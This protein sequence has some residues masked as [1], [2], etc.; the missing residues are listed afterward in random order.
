MKKKLGLFFL[1]S[2]SI[3]AR[4][5]TLES[6]IQLGMDNNKEIMIS[7]KEVQKTKLNVNV[8]FKEAL[9]S[10]VYTGSYNKSEYDRNVILSKKPTDR[11]EATTR[12]SKSSYAQSIS[13]N[14]PLFTGGV[15]TSGIKYAKASESI[16]E[17]NYLGKQRDVRLEII[18]MY[19][20][21]VATNKNLEAL[22]SSEKE[23]KA[24]YERQ[25]R[26]LDLELITKSDLL[27]TEY[28]LLDVQS[29]IIATSNLFKIQMENLKVKL[30][31]PITE[32]L[33]IREFT[34]PDNLVKNINFDI[35]KK[36]ALEESI[37]AKISNYTLDLAN[38]SKGI[39]RAEFMP[40]VN[41]FVSYGSEG[42]RRYYDGT[43]DDAE[44]RGGISVSWNLFEFGKSIDKYRVADLTEEQEKLKNT[45]TN[46][47]IEIGVT[48]AYLELVR[49]EKERD[50][51]EKAYLSA[52]EN[53]K[54]DSEK[55]EAGLISTVD[56]LKS[57]TQ[58]RESIVSYNKVVMDYLYAF[59]KYR[60]KLI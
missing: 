5:L 9:P 53:Y 25:K 21:I 37:D 34:V 55:Y 59:E 60:S 12:T 23:L 46:D 7:E 49:I 17:L 48:E 30:G 6:A 47:K 4:E 26:K 42:E 18:R 58:L 57:E 29:Q 22:K 28:S 15:V 54:M 45:L 52:K 56:F 24:T 20:D 36:R 19:S 27:K 43:L 11:N 16:A 2:Y 40:K 3:F 32:K 1:L 10:V 38:A 39:A 35:D 51:R 14:Q 13:I 33:Q 44:W 41:A 31:L 8:A 50:A